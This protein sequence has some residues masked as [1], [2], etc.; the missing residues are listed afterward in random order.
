MR[1]SKTGRGCSPVPVVVII[2]KGDNGGVVCG[3]LFKPNKLPV[4]IDC[5]L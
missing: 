2:R 1:T 3:H 5:S 4:I